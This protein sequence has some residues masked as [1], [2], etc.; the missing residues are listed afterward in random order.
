MGDLVGQILFYAL[1][2]KERRQEGDKGDNNENKSVEMIDNI[3][4]AERGCPPSQTVVDGAALHHLQKGF[5]RGIERAEEGNNG[6]RVAKPLIKL[7]N[8]A[9]DQGGEERNDN[10]QSGEVLKTRHLICSRI[11]SSS[12]VPYFLCM[13][14]MMARATPRVAT[15]TTIAVSINTWGRGFT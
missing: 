3:F 4:D 11:S 10:Q 5:H 9:Y 8:Y 14:R 15:P 7:P 12:T 2:C 1:L 6:N 13:S